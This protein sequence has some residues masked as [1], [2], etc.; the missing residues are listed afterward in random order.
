MKRKA[1]IFVLLSVVCLVPS[2]ALADAAAF[3]YVSRN[4]IITAEPAGAHSFMVNIINLSDFVIVVQPHEFIYR[5]ESGRHYIGQVFEREHKDAL[6][7][8]QRYTASS[9]LRERT[10]AGLKITGVFREQNAIEELSVRIGARRFFLQPMEQIAF[11]QLA[12]KIQNIDV[13]NLDSA[14]ELASANIQEMG[15]V[16]I[17]DGSPEWEKDWD[18]LLWT[19]A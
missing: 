17:T 6:G 14:A 19:T 13:K 18:G 9:L 15:R 4:Y 12:R 2:M 7:A 10:F 16:S 11:E 8:A 3:A 5:G 1:V